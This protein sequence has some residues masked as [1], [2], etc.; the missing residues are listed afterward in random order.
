MDNIIQELITRA[1]KL[2]QSKTDYIGEGDKEGMEGYAVLTLNDEN[3]YPVSSVVTIS[4]ADGIKWLTFLTEVNSNK[5]KRIA[6]SNKACVCLASSEYLISLVGTAEI[7]TDPEIKKEHWQE[8]VT[9][10]Y[11]TDWQNPEWCVLRFNTE[12]YNIFFADMGDDV[13][14]KGTL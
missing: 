5:A 10:Y 12:R 2:I 8:V 6:H 1:A 9:K 7:L 14:A 11:G 3:N 4:K 13:E